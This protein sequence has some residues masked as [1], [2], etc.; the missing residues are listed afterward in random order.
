MDLESEIRELEAGPVLDALARV[1]MHEFRYGVAAF[2]DQHTGE[3][4]NYKPVIKIL[5][6]KVASHGGR[7][8]AEVPQPK[9]MKY[10]GGS[11]SR[12]WS[13]AGPALE[14][15]D[16]TLQRR[17]DM[18]SKSDW[19][20]DGHGRGIGMVPGESPQLAIARAC[21]LVGLREKPD[22]MRAAWEALEGDD[23]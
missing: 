2:V 20:V 12:S 17:L 6:A 3:A 8:I 7:V 9:N 19:A 15:L 4:F 23:G 16:R 5:D 11:V 13:A 22:E 1:A 21:C 10:Y 18:G 14:W